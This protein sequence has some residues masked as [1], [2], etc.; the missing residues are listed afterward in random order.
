MY[1][2]DVHSNTRRHACIA[3]KKRTGLIAPFAA[4]LLTETMLGRLKRGLIALM[5][6]LA[7]NFEI[8]D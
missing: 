2:I 7:L 4:F 3:F 1:L 5:A 8:G 6:L